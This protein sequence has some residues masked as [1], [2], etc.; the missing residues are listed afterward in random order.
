MS[1]KRSASIRGDIRQELASEI[2]TNSND[3]AGCT[4]A[5]RPPQTVNKSERVESENRQPRRSVKCDSTM[6]SDDRLARVVR[7]ATEV[8]GALVGVDKPSANRATTGGT[9]TE[10]AANA[11]SVHKP[12]KLEKS[13]GVPT[14]LEAFIA[15]YNNCKRYNQWNSEESASFCMIASREMLVK[16]SGRLMTTPL[17][18]ISFVYCVIVLVTR[19]TWRGFVHSFKLVG[20]SQVSR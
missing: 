13:E 16:F 11:K 15:K 17:M 7:S 8:A 10:T 9:V 4:S 5:A 19:S 14:P 18:R 6:C 2:S 1:A 3:N 12:L 20:V